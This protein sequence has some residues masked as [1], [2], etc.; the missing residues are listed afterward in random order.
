MSESIAAAPAAARPAAAALTASLVDAATQ[1]FEALGYFFV[2]VLDAG[3]GPVDGEGPSAAVDFTGPWSGA[4]VVSV[5]PGVLSALA[6]NMLGSDEPPPPALQLD[7][8][9]EVA[10]V[11]C[12]SVLPTLGGPRAVFSL[13]APRVASVVDAVARGHGAPVVR[14]TLDLDGGRASVLWFVD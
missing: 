4:L 7:A 10:N 12:G 13:S 6:A 1:A 3:A 14:A 9:G 2:E 5:S 8:L 11:I